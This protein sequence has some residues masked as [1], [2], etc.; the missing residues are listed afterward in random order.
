MLARLLVQLLVR[1]YQNRGLTVF[2]QI[3]IDVSTIRLKTN[4][5]ARVWRYRNLIITIL[6]LHV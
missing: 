4:T 6:L 1:L 3:Q 5:V 2:G